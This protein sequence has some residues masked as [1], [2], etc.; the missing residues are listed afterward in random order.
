LPRR[1]LRTSFLSESLGLKCEVR[2]LA[3]GQ[4]APLLLFH[5]VK[6][7][8]A[9]EAPHLLEPLD[10]HERGQRLALAFDDEFVASEGNPVEH[11][12]DP[13]ADV[14]GRYFSDMCNSSNDSSC[15]RCRTQMV[16]D[17]CVI[18][19]WQLCPP[20]SPFLL[21]QLMLLYRWSERL[22]SSAGIPVQRFRLVA[23]LVSTLTQGSVR[24][25]TREPLHVSW[26]VPRTTRR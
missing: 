5:E 14:D 25:I 12:A 24:G 20:N 2:R 11:V 13:L 18:Y 21:R 6:G 22:S 4:W 9:G 1:G 16:G 15:Y 17:T 26:K 23:R 7:L 3:L 19:G 10:R 8:P